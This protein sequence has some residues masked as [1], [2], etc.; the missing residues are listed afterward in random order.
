M[1][2][3]RVGYLG[4]T[5]RQAMLCPQAHRPAAPAACTAQ[6]HKAADLRALGAAQ[7]HAL[8]LKD[9]STVKAA[10]ATYCTQ[11]HCKALKPS[12]L[13]VCMLKQ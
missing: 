10:L 7:S 2:L 6:H 11:A 1:L 9:D 13:Q 8:T 4:L 3:K 12:A 5:R